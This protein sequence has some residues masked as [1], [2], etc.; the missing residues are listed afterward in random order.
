MVAWLNSISTTDL[1]AG[2]GF[3]MTRGLDDE[4]LA[5]TDFS[6][7]LT[8]AGM[9][10]AVR[11]RLLFWKGLAAMA[12]GAA[13]GF[14]SS[15]LAHM[16]GNA[17][18]A[19]VVSALVLASAPASVTG[20]GGML[21]YAAVSRLVKSKVTNEGENIV[22]KFTDDPKVKDQFS[23]AMAFGSSVATSGIQN[24]MLSGKGVSL[25][26]VRLAVKSELKSKQAELIAEG[27]A[28]L[29]EYAWAQ[30]NAQLPGVANLLLDLKNKVGAIQRLSATAADVSRSNWKTVAADV[31]SKAVEDAGLNPTD[32]LTDALAATFEPT[33]GEQAVG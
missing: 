33:P 26:V 29:A 14:G 28:A 1:L 2:M 21:A 5:S 16:A 4:A 8:A 15:M 32:L 6:A 17:A 18:Q 23:R 22:G 9:P 27:K 10:A 24:G 20:F 13:V 12:S 7:A 30:A 31:V 19:M 25:K 3:N 11:R